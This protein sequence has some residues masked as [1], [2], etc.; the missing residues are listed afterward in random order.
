MKNILVLEGAGSSGKTTLARA[1]LEAN[2]GS[3]YFHAAPF[4]GWVVEAHRAMLDAAKWHA[5]EGKLVVIDRHWISEYVYGPIF[6]NAVACS[7]LDALELDRIIRKEGAYVLC[8]PS[9][10]TEHERRFQRERLEKKDL[11]PTMVAV[12]ERY[13]R[14]ATG[15]MHEESDDYLGRYIK[16]GDFTMK[17]CL[18]YDIDMDGRDVPKFIAKIEKE[19]G[20]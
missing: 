14:L 8:V 9:D 20:S 11:F 12:A 2:P 4:V 16:H 13:R 1:I 15:Y 7:D 19:L 5:R 3:L 10:A 18:V 17:D 6:R